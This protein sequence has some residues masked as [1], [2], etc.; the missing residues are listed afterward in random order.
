M[1]HSYTEARSCET[2]SASVVMIAGANRDGNAISK[3]PDE[4]PDFT[5]LLYPG[6]GP[7]HVEQITGD[8]NEVEILRLFDQPTKPVKAEMEISG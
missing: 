8:A 1:N 5:G 3:F 4:G 6:F 2:E 7:E